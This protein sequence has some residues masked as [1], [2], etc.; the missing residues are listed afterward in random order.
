[1]SLLT[2]AEIEQT[3]NKIGK[4][5]KQHILFCSHQTT[6]FLRAPHAV[7]VVEEVVGVPLVF[8][9]KEVGVIR[10]PVP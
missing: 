10:A 4:Q 6:L 5:N 7:A 8:Y 9:F 2:E 1:M 3:F